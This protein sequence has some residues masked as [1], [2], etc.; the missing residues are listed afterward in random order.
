MRERDLEY[1]EVEPRGWT[2]VWEYSHTHDGGRSSI[3]GGGGGAGEI[4]GTTATGVSG[5]DVGTSPAPSVQ[6]TVF[7]PGNFNG[8]FGGWNEF[9]FTAKVNG[10]VGVAT[11]SV[12]GDENMAAELLARALAE[13]SISLEPIS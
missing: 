11:I 12:M 9:T 8:N 13:G 10:Q 6:A 7:R 1:L 4:V 2:I 5:V 3:A